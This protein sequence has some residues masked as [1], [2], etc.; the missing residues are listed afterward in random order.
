MMSVSAGFEPR[1]GTWVILAPV[2][3]MNSS[4]DMRTEVPLPDDAMLTLPGLALT[5]SMISFT[6]FA[7]TLLFTTITFGTRIRPPTGAMSLTKLH[8]R[9]LYSVAVLR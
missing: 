6:F 3:S 8:D 5:W 4:P 2:I 1:Y 9:F 7:G